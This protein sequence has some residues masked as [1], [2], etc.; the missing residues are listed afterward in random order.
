MVNNWTPINMDLVNELNASWGLGPDSI[1][2]SGVYRLDEY[3]P[4]Q[5]YYFGKNDNHPNAEV[6][7]YTGKLF[8]Y[9]ETIDQ[10]FEEFL[11]GRLDCAIVPSS[12]VFEFRNDPRLVIA[13][14]ATSFRLNINSFGT[15]ENRDAYIAEHPDMGLSEF[16]PEPILQYLEMRQALQFGINRYEM[17]VNIGQ[18]YIPAFTY[19]A[20]TYF[21]DGESGISVRGTE[22]GQA[23]IDTY[24]LDNNGF[25]PDAAV[26]YFKEAVIKAIAEGY[27]TSG[28]EENPTIIELTLTYMPSGNM[29]I[30]DMIEY[31]ETQYETLLYDNE[32]HVGIDIVL[33][34]ASFPYGYYTGMM[35]ASFDLGLGGIS[36]SLLCPFNFLDTFADDNRSGFTLNW[37]IDTTTANIPIVY[38]GL[39]GVLVNETWSYNAMVSA[40]VGKVYVKDGQEQFKFDSNEE[41]INAYLDMEETTVV[42]SEVPVAGMIEYIMGVTPSQLAL[43]GGYD[44][45][46][47]TIVV[48][49]NG[50]HYLFVTSELNGQYELIEKVALFLDVTT[51]IEVDANYP[52]GTNNGQLI[53]DAAVQADTYL[54]G[55]GFTTLQE[56]A[57]YAEVPIAF[58]EVYSITW[59]GPYDGTD[60]YVVLHI[61]EYYI[62]YLWM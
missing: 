48:D 13:P 29:I 36:G 22:D 1:A 38:R 47:E 3:T 16:T 40:M 41:L 27:Y 39:D 52:L 62:P 54:Q 50:N 45:V 10:V 31:L 34:N 19:F 2:S 17:A 32:N 5:E 20:P 35:N 24:G 23:I 46:H 53:D 60:A 61:G 30:E 18:T 43:E 26:A 28:T 55:L 21:V 49:T 59:A 15:E 58:M 7:H 14:S 12:R 9:I 57:D 33:H 8:R 44:V 51:A 25:D 11:N 42:S 6:Y 37:G 4:L 56:I